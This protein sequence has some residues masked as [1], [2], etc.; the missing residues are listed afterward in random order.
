MAA[1]GDKESAMAAAL[2]QV[3]LLSKDAETMSSE[4]QVPSRAV[5]A[6]HLHCTAVH[7]A[8][9]PASGLLVGHDLLI[10]TTTW[11]LRCSCGLSSSC[12]RGR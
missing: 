8:T 5:D 10:L 6:T 9:A 1:E 7:T 4:A 2:R 3:T 11:V 12:V